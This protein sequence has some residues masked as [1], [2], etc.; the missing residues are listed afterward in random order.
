MTEIKEKL[1]A[2]IKKKYHASPEYPWARYPGYVAFR[3]SDNKKLFALVTAVPGNRLGLNGENVVD[4]LNVKVSDPFLADFP[5][6]QEGFFHGHPIEAQ[7]QTAEGMD[8]SIKSEILRRA[9]GF[10]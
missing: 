6:R 4:V 2:Y 7:T 1:F 8:R 9:D 3:Q 10:C 5:I